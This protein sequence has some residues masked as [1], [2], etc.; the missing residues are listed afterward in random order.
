VEPAV[1]ALIDLLRPDIK[2]NKR[3]FV[4]WLKARAS[5]ALIGLGLKHCKSTVTARVA[6][7]VVGHKVSSSTPIAKWPFSLELSVLDLVFL[8]D[9]VSAL[10]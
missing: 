9:R 2:L 8:V 6:V 5:L 4:A 10:F 7:T 3:E 1:R